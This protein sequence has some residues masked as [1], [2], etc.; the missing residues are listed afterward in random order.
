[1]LFTLRWFICCDVYPMAD[2]MS[3]VWYYLSTVNFCLAKN[4]LKMFCNIALLFK[5]QRF[6]M[7]FSYQSLLIAVKS[8]RLNSHPLNHYYP[9]S[10]NLVL[11]CSTVF[12][13][14]EHREKF[15]TVL[16]KLTC[17]FACLRCLKCLRL[18]RRRA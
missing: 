15:G 14:G 17:S 3:I 11:T 10:K 9:K 4:C 6:F 18:K 1:M 13:H 12:R 16:P 5:L 8:R 2:I 7:A